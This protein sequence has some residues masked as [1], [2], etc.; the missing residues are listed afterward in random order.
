MRPIMKIVTADGKTVE[1]A[2]FNAWSIDPEL[3]GIRIAIT[4]RADIISSDIHPEDV[5]ATA[6]IEPE[7]KEEILSKA[8]E[9]AQNQMLDMC[10][11]REVEAWIV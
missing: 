8:L 10:D 11:E 4:I 2:Y 5:E 3:E 6:N 9:L 7:R 1:T